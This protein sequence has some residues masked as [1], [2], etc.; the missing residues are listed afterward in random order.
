MVMEMFTPTKAG[1]ASMYTLPCG[2]ECVM[3]NTDL[4]DKSPRETVNVRGRS[5]LRSDAVNQP[6]NKMN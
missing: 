2:N 1:T 6:T 5:D 3:L 4:A